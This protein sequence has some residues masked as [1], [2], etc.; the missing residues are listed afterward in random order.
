MYEV[1][2]YKITFW[3]EMMISAYKWLETI[4]LPDGGLLRMPVENHLKDDH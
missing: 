1:S 4:G 2:A 3:E